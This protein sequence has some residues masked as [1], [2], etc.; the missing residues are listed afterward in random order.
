MIYIAPLSSWN[1]AFDTSAH[2]VEAFLAFGYSI[3]E[4]VGEY[5]RVEVTVRSVTAASIA[6]R[7]NHYYVISEQSV[8]DPAPVELARGVVRLLPTELAEDKMTVVL[9]CVPPSV[10]DV[11]DAYADAHLRTDDE[12]Y[13]PLTLPEGAEDDADQALLGKSADWYWDRK[14]LALSTTPLTPSNPI[15]MSDHVLA[16]TLSVRVGELPYDRY[17]MQATVSWTQIAKGT[18]ELPVGSQV[19]GIPTY[20]WQD[21]QQ[22]FPKAGAMVGDNTGW[23]VAEA[24]C[25][26]GGVYQT[27][28]FSVSTPDVPPG[29]TVVAQARL[30]NCMIRLAYD[31]EQPREET[32]TLY[33]DPD[34]QKIVADGKHTVS[35]VIKLRTPTIDTSTPEWTSIDDETFEPKHYDVDDEVQYNGKTFRC[36][37][38][39]DADYDLGFQREFWTVISTK[40]PLN[41]SAYSYFDSARG[42]RTLAHMYLRGLETILRAYRCYEVSF[43]CSWKAARDLTVDKSVALGSMRGLP[44]G[45]V[46]GKVTGVELTADGPSRKAKITMGVFAGRGVAGKPSTGS[47]VD[48]DGAKFDMSGRPYSAP[49]NVENLPF[50]AMELTSINEAGEQY[51][52]MWAADDPKATLESA[53]TQATITV[54]VLQEQDLLRRGLSAN[55]VVPVPKGGVF[56][57][58]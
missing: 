29:S 7:L 17:V 31:Y 38:A 48:A 1:T 12:W 30:L 9:D 25:T 42:R 41:K 26:D 45:G 18:Q 49:V 54:P 37:E 56:A 34:G 43:E 3:T 8:D 36:I 11:K 39:H 23:S 14:T 20:T 44:A 24:Y 22:T 55:L 19:L 21:F 15:D 57:N 51:A 4:T 50:V 33:L 47:D 58:E 13:D 35:E 28:E 52:A 6:S 32:A 46:V 53:P 16:G 40:A 2:A 27:H 10:D 5:P